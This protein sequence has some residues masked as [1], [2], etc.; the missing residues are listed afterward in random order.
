[1]ERIYR[2]G[3]TIPRWL[4]PNYHPSSA[5][6]K[7]AAIVMGIILAVMGV[8]LFMMGLVALF[9][10][11]IGTQDRLLNLA[12]CWTFGFFPMMSWLRSRLGRRMSGQQIK[13]LAL[14]WPVTIPVLFVT[15]GL[16]R[17]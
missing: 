8:S 15:G 9:G 10:L 7:L 11:N 5:M 12:L 14:A 13:W 4:N 6:E 1:M 3:L 2:L 16:R 17:R